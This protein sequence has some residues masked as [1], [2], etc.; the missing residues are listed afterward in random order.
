M[1]NSI[2]MCMHTYCNFGMLMMKV[3]V[4][5]GTLRRDYVVVTKTLLF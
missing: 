3:N 1:Q 5:A 2:T 4:H